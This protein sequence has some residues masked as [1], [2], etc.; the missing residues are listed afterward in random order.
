[1][2]KIIVDEYSKKE[3][4]KII[5]SWQ[6]KLTWNDLGERASRELGLES[7]ISRFTLLS[8]DDIKL[9]FAEKKKQLKEAPV[10]NLATGDKALDKAYER[11]KSLEAKNQR[12]ESE[13][14]VTR[15]QFVRWQHNL[16]RMGVD[17]NE[18]QKVLDRPLV[19]FNRAGNQSK[20]KDS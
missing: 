5:D 13:L 14:A 8:Y 1:M 2:P 18:V 17:M 11:I 4:L 6:G 7:P 15:E 10:V 20:N 3:I 16:Y 19:D 9:A 12:L